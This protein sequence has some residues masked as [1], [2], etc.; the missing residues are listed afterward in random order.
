MKKIQIVFIILAII[1]VASFLYFRSDSLQE[2]KIVKRLTFNSDPSPPIPN[3]T[4]LIVP[5]YDAQQ[6]I[7]REVCSTIFGWRDTNQINP[8]NFTW[9]NCTLVQ[10]G[11]CYCGYNPPRFILSG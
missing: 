10:K 2:S 7:D 5:Y 11:Y 4:N 8:D 6:I 9:S 1:I 3:R